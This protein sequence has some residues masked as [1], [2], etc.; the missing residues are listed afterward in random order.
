MPKGKYT[1][2]KEHNKKIS[3]ALKGR[4]LTKKWKKRKSEATKRYYQEHPEERVK[5]SKKLKE[6]WN[7]GKRVDGW[8]LTKEQNR[9]NSKIHRGKNNSNWK[10]GISSLV[11]L[12]R[13]N[14]RYKEWRS[15]VF[16]RD[17]FTCVLCGKNK[18][19]VEA[20]HYPKKFSILFHESKVKTL[21]EALDYT[22]LWNINNGRT[23]CRK[24]HNKT[25]GGNLNY[26]IRK[27][28]SSQGS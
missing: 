21:E 6:E 8:K 4:I 25:K 24:C 3:E 1:R 16:T 14:K 27:N 26:A 28:Y 19:W 15:D 22:E 17:D 7:L 12:I 2:T 23:L 5:Q 9:K 13:K 11:Q 10:G 20:D 18:C